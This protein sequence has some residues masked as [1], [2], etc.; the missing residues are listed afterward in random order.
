MPTPYWTGFFFQRP[1]SHCVHHQKKLHKYN[2]SD[3]PLWDI[4]FGTFRNP[5]I[6]DADCG[7]EN[8]AELNVV[9]MLMFKDVNTHL[10]NGCIEDEPSPGLRD[11]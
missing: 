5:K 3:L 8:D 7:F 6:W 1:E 9:D 2:F 4:L 10:Q 11:G